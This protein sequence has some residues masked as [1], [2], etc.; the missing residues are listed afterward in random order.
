MTIFYI[1]KRIEAALQAIQEPQEIRLRI[2]QELV[3]ATHDRHHEWRTLVL[4]SAQLS[5][6]P[7]ARTV[8]LRE[9]DAKLGQLRMYTDSRSDKVAELTHQPNALLLFWSKRLSWQ[10]RVR[11]STMVHLTGP[12]VDSAWQRVR[13]SAAAGDYLSPS[14]PGTALSSAPASAA[15]N[16]T[17][18]IER[19]HL[20]VVEARVGAIDW[21]ELGR[22]GHRRAQ[23]GADTW[24]WLVP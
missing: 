5:G 21:L 16:S 23:L 15:T 17:T 22:G 14:A 10:L 8:V 11:V 2:W 12:R 9:A 24:E 3:R 7:N 18:S 13:Q 1:K 20:A 4:A 19:H 6:A